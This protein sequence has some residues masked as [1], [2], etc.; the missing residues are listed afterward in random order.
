MKTHTRIAKV[1]TAAAV[2]LASCSMPVQ[3]PVQTQQQQQN[4]QTLVEQLRKLIQGPSQTSRAY[5]WEEIV[6]DPLLAPQPLPQVVWP[7]LGA[8][9]YQPVVIPDV[10]PSVVWPAPGA[11]DFE[12]RPP[13]PV[14]AQPQWLVGP[15]KD[16][17]APVGGI[18]PN[19][20]IPELLSTVVWPETAASQPIY[21]HTVGVDERELVPPV[22]APA[23]NK[24]GED[25]L[26]RHPPVV[27]PPVNNVAPDNVIAINP[28][29]EAAAE[30]ALRVTPLV[31]PRLTRQDVAE[32]SAQR[33]V[34]GPNWTPPER[35][36]AFEYVIAIHPAR[37]AA[38]ERAL[39]VTPQT[40]QRVTRQEMAERSAQRA[41]DG[42]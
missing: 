4:T 17:R 11:G 25:L 36:T 15:V 35:E 38:A 24:A 29:R 16:I 21:W 23:I 18:N 19:I 10:L 7:A 1:A 22:I 12:T 41:V 34:D 42:P 14:L 33:A 31:A 32:R 39:R 27:A 8:G 3:V 30:R 9:D 40:V 6:P 37:Q 2:L 26:D 5:P 13:M 28:A 20:V